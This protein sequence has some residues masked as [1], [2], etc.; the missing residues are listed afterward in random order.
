MVKGKNLQDTIS[1][2]SRYADIIVLRHLGMRQ[3]LRLEDVLYQENNK[4]GY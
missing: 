2:V 4:K 1:V 3:L